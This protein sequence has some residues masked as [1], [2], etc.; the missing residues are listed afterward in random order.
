M[1]RL[2]RYFQ[3]PSFTQTQWTTRNPYLRKGETGY[4][5]SED[6]G[7][8]IGMK[9][10][11]GLWNSLELLGSDLYPY[12]DEVTNPIGDA[13]GTLANT[14][15]ASILKKMLSP[16]QAPVLSGLTNN[17]GAGGGY[18]SSVVREIGQALTGPVN[19]TFL[20][21]Q[22]TNLLGAS[23]INV[24]AGSTFSNEGNFAFT[25]P[26]SLIL[27]S[28]LNPV[29]TRTVTISVK[30]THLNGVSNT[31]TTAIHFYPKTMSVVSSLSDLTGSQFMAAAN[32][33]TRVSNSYRADYTFAGNGYSWL[34]IASMLNPTNLVFT[35]V[36]NPN[37]PANYSMESKGV[38][39]I[40]NGV[41]TYSYNLY[42]STYSL[43]NPTILRVA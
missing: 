26:I 40:N 5:L 27:A 13:S 42:R 7:L 30:A 9:V 10:G 15:L 3:A 11:P 39:S 22:S 4:V 36:T 28:P 24:T 18:A 1:K 21:S 43:L 35:D 34:A 8:I 33:A 37:L 31:V 6:T 2:I 32:R 41:T 12:T 29:T 25:L 19:L 14:S 17:A 38:I 23:P 20:L 16:Y